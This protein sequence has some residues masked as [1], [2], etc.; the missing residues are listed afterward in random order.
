MDVLSLSGR[1]PLPV[2]KHFLIGAISFLFVGVSQAQL[3]PGSPLKQSDA[4]VGQNPSILTE[5]ATTSRFKL[6]LGPDDPFNGLIVGTEGEVP[7]YRINTGG[8]A[9]AAG[10]GS[11][12]G[13]SEDSASNPSAYLATS[14]SNSNTTGSS[15]TSTG[16]V[17][18]TMALET[19]Q[20]ERWD[21]PGGDNMEWDFPVTVGRDYK[22]RLYFSEIA[23][24]GSGLRIFDVQIEGSTP[25]ALDDLDIYAQAGGQHIGF[26]IEVD[27]L[28]GDSNIDID[29]IPITENPKIN[30]IEIVQD[31]NTSTPQDAV[32][33]LVDI[34]NDGDLDAFVGEFAGTI[35]YIQNTGSASVPVFTT[36]TGSNNPLSQEDVGEAAHP[37]MADLDN[38]GDIDLLIGEGDGD[39]YYYENTGSASTPTFTQQTG[40]SN[41]MDGEDI[42]GDSAPTFVDIDNDNDFDLI[43]GESNGEI[44]FYENTGSV[45]SPTFT[46]QTGASNPFDGVDLG[47]DVKPAF[48]DVDGDGDYDA[49]F[50]ENDGQFYYYEN[51]G[52][53]SVPSFSLVTGSTNPFN[54]IDIGD[55]P[56]PYFVDIDNDGDT[57]ALFGADEGTIYYYKNQTPSAGPGGLI[58][59]LHLWLKVDEEV[60][61]N[62]SAVTEWKDQSGFDNHAVQANLT[63]QPVLQDTILNY[64]PG[65][66]FTEDFL[67][68]S[69]EI[70]AASVPDVTVVF[71]YI[72]SA[73]PAGT[74]WG[75]SSGDW[76]RFTWDTASYNNAI[77]IGG[78]SN[79]ETDVSNLYV[80]DQA[81]ISTI[82]F[83]EDASNGSSVYVN[84]TLQQQFTADQDG[85]AG[86][87][88]EVGSWGGGEGS[89]S[90]FQ[91]YI[92]E[93]IVYKDLLSTQEQ[94]QIETYLALKYGITLSHDYLASDATTIWDATA[95]ASYS[96]DIAGI[97]RDDA[98]GLNQKQSTSHTGGI[99]EMGLGTIAIDNDSNSNTFSSDRSFLI[100]GHD[101]GSTA[102]ATAYL[103]STRMARVWAVEEMG[104]V[105]TVEIRVPD[106]YAVTHLIVSASS[107]ITTPTEY[108]LTDNGDG[109]MS[110]TV[111]LSDGEF[112][113]FANGV[114]PGG[115]S[116]NT[117]IWLRA[118]GGVTESSN[119]VSAWA[120]Q[121]GNGNDA[122]QGTG[123]FQPTFTASALNYNPS[124][125]FDGSDDVLATSLSINASTY[126]DFTMIAVYEPDVDNAGAPWG[127]DD[128]N[129]DRFIWDNASYNEVVSIGTTGLNVPGL[130]VPGQAVITTVAYDE[131]VASGSAVYIDGT[132]QTQFTADHDP[133]TSSTLDIGSVG[134]NNH[135]FDGQVYEIIGY[136][137]LLSSTDRE[138]VETYVALKYGIS[139]GHDYLASD[140][141]TLW[142]AT[143]N[144][145]YNNDIAGIGRDDGSALDQRQSTSQSGGIIE[146]GLGA[147]A[148]DNASNANAFSVDNSFMVWGHD[149][150][151]SSV[152]TA[153]SGTLVYSR[154][155]RVW[156]VEETGTVSTVEVQIPGSY[157][158]NFLIVSS[159][160]SFTSPTEY[161]LTDNGDGTWSTTLDFSDGVFF[162]F[163]T[164]EAPGGVM[165]NLRLWTKADAGITEASNNVSVWADQSGNSYDFSDSGTSTYTYNTNGLNYNPEIENTDGSNRRLVNTSSITLQTVV[166]VT[167]PD[168]PG[169]CDNP[170]S[171]YNAD[172]EGIR[173]CASSGAAWNLPGNA[174][175]FT[176]ASGQAWYNG[177]VA[178]NPTHNNLSSIIVAEAPTTTTITAGIELGDSQE[179]RYWHGS[180]AEVIGFGD[181]LSSSEREQVQSYLAIKYG[182]TVSNNYLASDGTTLW[183]A[184]A[185]ASYHNDIAGIGRDDASGLNQKQSDTSILSAALGA[186][187]ADNAS[188]SNSFSTDLAFLLLGHN[189]GSLTESATTI[190][191]SSSQMLGRIW[192]AEETNESGTLEVQ[193]DLSSA[194]ITGTAASAFQLVLDTNT[195][196]S[197][198]YRAITTASSFSSNIATF[199]SV[200]IEDGDY[201]IV[202]TDATA[203]STD[204]PLTDG[205]AGD[206]VLGQPDFDSSTANNGGVSAARLSGPTSMA[207]GPTGKVFVADTKN[208][209]ILRW[210]SA[211]AIIDGSSAEAVLG[212]ADFTSTSANRGGSVAANTLYE[213]LGIYVTS[214]GAL[215][216]ADSQNHR[217]L[218]FDNAESAS[219]GANADAV[220]GQGDFTSNDPNRRENV[221]ANSLRVPKDV[222]V[223]GSGNL[224]VADF[225]NHR[226]L[227]YDNV[228]A[229][230]NG[231]TADGVL[232]QEV[233]TTNLRIWK[234]GNTDADSFVFPSGVYVDASGVLW[235]ADAGNSRILRFDNAASKAD[236]SDADG[237]LGQDDFTSWNAHKGGLPAAGTMQWPEAGLHGDN[238]GRLYVADRW[239]DRI[240]WYHNAASKANGADADGV[241]GQSSFTSR[242]GAV[243]N[244][245]FNSATDVFVDTST[246]YIWVVD[247]NHNRVLR[248]NGV[249][250][251]IGKT[252]PAFVLAQFDLW[253]KAEEGVFV[254]PEARMLPAN[255]EEVSVWVDQ[256]IHRFTA[257]AELP[258]VFIQ[259]ALNGYP[260][261]SF[262]ASG[263]S[264]VI[265][266]G[267]FGETS[268]NKASVWAVR[269]VVPGSPTGFTLSFERDGKYIEYGGSKNRHIP[270]SQIAKSDESLDDLYLGGSGT[271]GAALVEL[272]LTFKTLSKKEQQ[273]ITSY[274][275]LK[276][277][278]SLDGPYLSSK[279]DTLWKD[280]KVYHKGIAGIG[281]DDAFGLEHL[282]SSP[283]G[284]DYPLRIT[285][286]S[287][288]PDPIGNLIWA[289]NGESLSIDQAS[290]VDIAPFRM[291]RTWKLHRTGSMDS[292]TV[293]LPEGTQAEYVLV[294]EYDSFSSPE[295]YSIEKTFE[296]ESR[297]R[298]A[299][300]TTRYLTLASTRMH[301]ESPDIPDV[302]ALHQNYPNPFAPSTTIPFDLPED[303][304][305]SL[306]IYDLLGRKVVTVLDEDVLAGR[307]QVVYVPNGLASG[308]YFYELR[309]GERQEIGKM[310]YKK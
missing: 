80:S 75:A 275:A 122:T 155:A 213:P 4:P 189:N 18:P 168:N 269:D 264:M 251:A 163:G 5:L 78:G 176:T 51:T 36:Q 165:S 12:I 129:W 297:V 85:K 258:P 134:N 283:Y 32:P 226:V 292:V 55:D 26:M 282:D 241:I 277:G 228:A 291:A 95:N 203:G 236:G 248:F 190:D 260:A 54:G 120:D 249:S 66:L 214:S 195:D 68:T 153:F 250:G 246:D 154:M 185:N 276:Y 186:L 301:E 119:V 196:P 19:F 289:H 166:I 242:H 62:F 118:D 147:L 92:L 209:R 170:F 114:G 215:Y 113:T 126:P 13:W 53:V 199:S 310:I 169:N 253:L 37:A 146:I 8:S 97:G 142:N 194:T 206:G 237:V 240:L 10:D 103:S 21:S 261:I 218:R 127:D 93:G 296:G 174:N 136:T 173:A 216:V 105:G 268:F 101:N 272:M 187:A 87:R 79:I 211:N 191:G 200:D 307:H 59:D 63:Y 300:A 309:A 20:S 167:H 112:F 308:V 115:V 3:L 281:R 57:D 302:F 266:G 179:S 278:F 14:G 180:I 11:A 152:A 94:N 156:K 33:V 197:D 159:S 207:T 67:D 274:L 171:E 252:S 188:N 82:A 151:S 140:G 56:S 52:S 31:E 135:E 71:V 145:S 117:V 61:V 217:V 46:Q 245:S 202:V 232:G 208:N 256:S 285:H 70:Q 294:D 184:T 107:S 116:A 64:Q 76:D 84:G 263:T 35:N 141:T 39:F 131:D 42:G 90:K 157:G 109:T 40:A 286:A 239:G 225:L 77:G 73:D 265:H 121:S 175:G 212:Q 124:I 160:S 102:V 221:T 247:Y 69:L 44:N 227:R 60:S 6:Q 172:D 149:N 139:Q 222:F 27:V 91:G 41:P 111:D 30:A 34:D 15:Q 74:L 288:S 162:T 50:G 298:I 150:G 29:F 223:D 271:T 284:D 306:A 24:S 81:N 99:V 16:D 273:V 47:T 219:D 255:Q 28:A 193:V 280:T 83:D 238:N 254:D 287:V 45:S 234:D 229:K 244:A 89:S 123:S 164:G 143:T 9:V 177:T 201:L 1:S 100:W 192:L 43:I 198:G 299:L 161:L 293:Y 235:V 231:D 144:A 220:L 65:I 178:S 233:F 7:V 262:N 133:E 49:M 279:G 270:K 23:V 243:D 304:R 104:T 138:K 158:A 183:D 303:A 48:Y 290:S 96:N 181:A 22:V 132:L 204:D 106:S 108:T 25:A 137:S 148:S 267:L 205:Q 125:H 17:G 130:F 86:A 295:L 230:S 128:S 58:D 182:I 110:A 88:F 98:S 72:P 224:W 38:D 2:F 259:N 257:V 305:V 210:S